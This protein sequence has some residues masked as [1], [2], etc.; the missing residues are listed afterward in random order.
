GRYVAVACTQRLRRGSAT[1]VTHVGRRPAG[2]TMR[3]L[4]R[5]RQRQ[6]RTI[7][8][9]YFITRAVAPRRP[10]LRHRT[11]NLYL[12]TRSVD[13]FAGGNVLHY[14]VV[15]GLAPRGGLSPVGNVF[16]DDILGFSLDF[17]LAHDFFSDLNSVDTNSPG[18]LSNQQLPNGVAPSNC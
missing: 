16:Q 12:V 17:S 11:A 10:A 2:L 14:Y 9:V 1:H 3:T 13:N 7:P 5:R 6:R 15:T 18:L 8:F 4:M